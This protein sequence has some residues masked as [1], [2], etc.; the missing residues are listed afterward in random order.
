M[1]FES[2]ELEDIL[3]EDLSSSSLLETGTTWLLAA[4]LLPD[5]VDELQDE[6]QSLLFWDA[7]RSN[8]CNPLEVDM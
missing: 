1:L 4:E 3:D 7:L 5:W 6:L 2:F 8:F